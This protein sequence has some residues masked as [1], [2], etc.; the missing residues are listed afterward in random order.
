MSL[1]VRRLQVLANSV[2]ERVEVNQ[3]HLIDK[4]LARFVYYIGTIV[5]Y[6]SAIMLANSE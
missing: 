2:E 5:V 1:D 6:Q 4:I 3:R